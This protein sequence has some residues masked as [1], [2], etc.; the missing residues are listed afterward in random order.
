MFFFSNCIEK[1]ELHLFKF[2]EKTTFC[3]LQIQNDI[4]LTIWYVHTDNMVWTSWQYGMDILTMVSAKHTTIHLYPMHSELL[5]Q[6]PGYWFATWYFYINKIMEFSDK[7]LETSAFQH[8]QLKTL[9]VEITL[10]CS[11]ISNNIKS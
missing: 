5:E 10:H 11:H 8:L 1:Y 2:L 7:I 9:A 3:L 4:K 6:L